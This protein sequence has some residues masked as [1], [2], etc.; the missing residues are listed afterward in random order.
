MHASEPF[1]A[2]DREQVT[3]RLAYAFRTPVSLSQLTYS[4]EA[5]YV[6]TRK[7]EGLV[8]SPLDFLAHLTVHI[9][10]RYSHMRRYG[11]IYASAARRALGLKTKAQVVRTKEKISPTWARLLARIFGALP[12]LCPSCHNEMTLQTIVTNPSEIRALVPEV[13]RAPPRKKLISFQDTHAGTPIYEV[14]EE[15]APYDRIDSQESPDSDAHFD[16]RTEA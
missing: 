4:K 8:F 11:G 15:A 10:N 14:A 16:Q 9:P 6:R 1:P 3:R 2:S 12:I 13:S 7:G 5:V